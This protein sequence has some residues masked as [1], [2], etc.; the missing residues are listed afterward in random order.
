M[1]V[2]QLPLQL[3]S[4]LGTVLTLRGGL[5]A[6]WT[7]NGEA[8]APFSTKARQDMGIDPA[9][10]AGQTQAPGA[11]PVGGSLQFTIGALVRATSTPGTMP[12]LHACRLPLT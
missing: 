4:P 5:D 2:R 12:F 7:P 11:P 8:P 1:A 6:K 10:F 9:A 3:R